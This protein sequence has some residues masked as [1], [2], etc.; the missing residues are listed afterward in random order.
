M[1]SL[2]LKIEYSTF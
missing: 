1:N 2:I